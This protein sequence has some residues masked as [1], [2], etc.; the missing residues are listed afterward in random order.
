M[1]LWLRPAA[2][3]QHFKTMQQLQQLS[4]LQTDQRG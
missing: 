1:Q 2:E 3:G 4:V